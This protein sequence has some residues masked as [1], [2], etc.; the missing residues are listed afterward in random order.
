MRVVSLAQLINFWVIFCD[1]FFRSAGETLDGEILTRDGAYDIFTYKIYKDRE[2]EASTMFQCILNIPHT[3][4][5][6]RK[7]I[8][9]FPGKKIDAFRGSF[10]FII[11]KIT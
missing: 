10:L 8:M 5:R 6:L 9:Y 4:Y 7:N 1:V 3:D 2:L 11:I